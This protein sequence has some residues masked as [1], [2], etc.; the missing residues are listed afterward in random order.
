M[1]LAHVLFFISMG[2]FEFIGANLEH[3]ISY[4]SAGIEKGKERKYAYGDE[5]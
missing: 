5:G 3:N 4:V 2:E 1:H